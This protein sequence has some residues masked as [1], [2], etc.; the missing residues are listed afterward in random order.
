LLIALALFAGAHQL[1]V[2]AATNWPATCATLQ[3]VL[4]A[5]TTLAGD[6]VTLSNGG[7]PCTA[8]VVTYP[9]SLPSQQ[10]TLTGMVAGDGLNGQGAAQLL[11]GSNV[12]ATVI[13]NLTFENGNVS[14][15]G[16][17][18]LISGT[19]NPTISNCI[20]L[21][22]TG[23]GTGAVDLRGGGGPITITGNTFGGTGAGNGN[24]S[25]GSYAGA[26]YIDAN[27]DLVITN[28]SFIDNTSAGGRNGAGESGAVFALSRTTGANVTFT[29]NT[30]TGNSQTA[31]G[32][33][34]GGA[35]LQGLNFTVTGNTFN[36]NS[37]GSG[38]GR[39]LGNFGGGLDIFATGTG[40]TVNQ[41]HNLF[42][43]N[44]VGAW[45]DAAPSSFVYD[46]GGGEYVQAP[47]I[48]SFDDTYTG[49]VVD[50][51]GGIVWAA[52][53][54]LGVQ[55]LGTTTSVLQAEN[56]VATNNSAAGVSFG[57]GIYAGY[58]S[59]CSTSCPSQVNLFDSTIDANSA[60]NG[61]GMSG[62]VVAA[63]AANVT[64]SIV[65]GNTGNVAQIN[66]GP[67]HLTVAYSD[68]CSAASTA[69]PG[70]GN[71]CVDPN[72]VNPAGNDVHE[73]GGGPTVNA[74]SN[75]LIPT[76]LTTD[77]M[78]NT[79]IFGGTVD[80]GAAE[81]QPKSLTTSTGPGVPVPASGAI[82][83]PALPAGFGLIT[84]GALLLA[85]LR[86]ATRLR[87]ARDGGAGA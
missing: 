45:S 70:T 73:K 31:G 43:S 9:I 46:G 5:P 72:L 27:S 83:G 79:R 7:V 16:G 20:F 10:I 17:A 13:T 12:G 61:P 40:G 19:D 32:G 56:L 66:Y 67:S 51:G 14:G 18:I 3:A 41:S 44:H 62:G 22:N 64:N 42:E 87:R 68:S 21:G 37:I 4:N 29:G 63:D 15:Y 77:Y 28:N 75:A 24:T 60:A 34:G 36:G 82:S 76:G 71:I 35:S 80:M 11:T 8:P 59:G 6:T 74:G 30:L 65:M 85:L 55:G 49:N 69:Y 1:S 26:L 54:G 23:T 33:I 52:G 50:A 25:T 39:T 84:A 47:T 57:G 48:D 86:V 58:S 53:G 2:R 38:S 78:G 81:F